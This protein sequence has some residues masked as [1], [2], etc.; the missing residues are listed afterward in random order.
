M[1]TVGVQPGRGFETPPILLMLNLLAVWHLVSNCKVLTKMR[2]VST[3][4]LLY[5]VF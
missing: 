4:E 5:L 3:K 2:L 1:D